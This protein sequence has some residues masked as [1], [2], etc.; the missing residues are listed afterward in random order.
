[1]FDADG[2]FVDM[3]PSG[4][5]RYYPKWKCHKGECFGIVCGRLAFGETSETA[6]EQFPKP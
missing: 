1:M 6:Y 2:S 3:S 5:I 4:A